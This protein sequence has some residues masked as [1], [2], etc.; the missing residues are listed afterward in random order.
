MLILI[1]GFSEYYYLKDVFE[2]LG[3][4]H[5]QDSDYLNCGVIALNEACTRDGRLN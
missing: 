5:I 1:A 2:Q 4:P 3:F